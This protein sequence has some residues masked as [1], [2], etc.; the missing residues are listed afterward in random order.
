MY[1]C[2]CKAVSQRV[3]A[4]AIEDGARTVD[5]VS[6]CTGAGTDCGSCRRSIARELERAQQGKRECGPSRAQV[7]AEPALQ[8]A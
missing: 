5:A 6:A 3:V 4:E 1:V 2:I 8:P 7:V